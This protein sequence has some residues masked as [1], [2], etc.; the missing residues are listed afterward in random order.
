[1]TVVVLY[2]FLPF[3]V[4]IVG[5]GGSLL[6]MH[7]IDSAMSRCHAVLSLPPRILCLVSFSV[8]VYLPPHR[9]LL[10]HPYPHGGRHP[11]QQP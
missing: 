10:T 5:G 4:C 7:G 8:V 6:T 2:I 9:V 3:L 1:M 11:C